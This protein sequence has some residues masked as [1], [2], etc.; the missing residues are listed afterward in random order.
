[1]E[2]AVPFW[3][4]FILGGILLALEILITPSGFLLCIGTA[5][6]IVGGISSFFA[7]IP[8]VWTIS[9]FALLSISTCYAW[10]SIL[11]K[12]RGGIDHKD[13]ADATLN[14]KTQQLKGLQAVLLEPLKNGKGRININDS[15][16]PVEADGD[17]PA[18]TRVEVLE[19]NGVTLKIQR[20]PDHRITP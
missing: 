19:V 16:W 17:Y 18:G 13:G 8:L 9:L 1:M 11:R 14:V 12:Q 4:W 20:F 10:W 15:S 2:Y 3:S 7:A 6:C 5:A